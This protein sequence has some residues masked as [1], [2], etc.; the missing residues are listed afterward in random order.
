VAASAHQHLVVSKALQ[1][2]QTTSDIRP[3]EGDARVHEVARMLGGQITDT[4]R[5]HAQAML[6]TAHS[7]SPA[8][9]SGAKAKPRKATTTRQEA[10]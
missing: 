10:A 5:A 4:S 6:T 8:D 9:T 3:V 7:A 2:S 1:G